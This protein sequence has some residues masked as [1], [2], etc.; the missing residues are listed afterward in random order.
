MPPKPP[1]C[2]GK[3]ARGRRYLASSVRPSSSASF[4]SRPVTGGASKSACGA[5]LNSFGVDLRALWASEKSRRRSHELSGGGCRP[6]PEPIPAVPF[7]MAGLRRSASSAGVAGAF[8]RAALARVGR[9]RSFFGEF[10]D[11]S[12]EFAIAPHMGRVRGGGKGSL[13]RVP[14]PDGSRSEALGRFRPELF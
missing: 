1:G 5:S 12:A 14:R 7:L 2:V 9:A 3:S 10:L 13:L 8:G 6:V 11:L 4:G